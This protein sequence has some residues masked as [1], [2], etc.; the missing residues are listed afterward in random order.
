[1]RRRHSSHL[2][3]TPAA[4]ASVRAARPPARRASGRSA[5][6]SLDGRWSGGYARHRCPGPVFSTR[7]RA[8]TAAFTQNSSRRVFF[9]LAASFHRRSRTATCKRQPFRSHRLYAAHSRHVPLRE[10]KVTVQL[11]FR[12]DVSPSTRCRR[13]RAFLFGAEQKPD[14]GG[15]D[16]ARPPPRN[17]LA[18]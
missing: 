4:E 14:G 13:Q 9:L 7:S 17:G 6:Q 15:Q 12:G 2:W 10:L 8:A 16:A 11:P 5:A 1:M 18:C 3:H